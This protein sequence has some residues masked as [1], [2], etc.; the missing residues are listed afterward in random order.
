MVTNRN[1]IFSIFDEL[2]DTLKGMGVKR[3][4]LFGSFA[5]DE[6]KRDSDV[7][8][9]VSF[10]P[11]YKNYDTF[12]KLGEL[13]EERFGRKVEI[14]TE[15][16]ISPHFRREIEK[17]A[18]F[19]EIVTPFDLMIDRGLEDSRNNRFVENEEMRNRMS[20]WQS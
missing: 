13:L 4:G 17:D 1:E 14:I 20:T 9:L 2:K 18:G 19:Y 3:I 6:G 7:D 10:L 15:E 11:G 5:R 12:F 8:I 16:S